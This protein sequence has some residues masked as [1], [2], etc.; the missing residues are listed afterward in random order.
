MGQVCVLAGRAAGQMR[1]VASPVGV[2]LGEHCSGQI[3][4]AAGCQCYQVD[5]DVTELLLKGCSFPGRPGLGPRLL[6]RLPLTE[7]RTQRQ[8]HTQRC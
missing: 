1:W 3:Y 4:T 6:I 7:D 2:H 5:E 8:A